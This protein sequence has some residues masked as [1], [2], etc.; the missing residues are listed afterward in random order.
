MVIRELIDGGRGGESIL[1]SGEGREGAKNSRTRGKGGERGRI[2]T[3]CW[4]KN[5]M[6]LLSIFLISLNYLCAPACSSVD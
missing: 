3:R 2:E 4:T 5:L 1:E 6:A